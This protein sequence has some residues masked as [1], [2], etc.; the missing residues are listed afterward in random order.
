MSSK[1]YHDF[2]KPLIYICSPNQFEFIRANELGYEN[3]LY[4]FL[5]YRN[6]S[7]TDLN[8][9]GHGSKDV[10]E[11][12]NEM[13]VYNYTGLQVLD[14]QTV[15]KQVFMEN[16]GHCLML[17]NFSKTSLRVITF[18]NIIFISNIL[19]RILISFLLA[20]FIG[21]ILVFFH[22]WFQGEK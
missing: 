8:W 2:D 4:Y 1:L 3:K 21:G 11:T 10:N 20:G 19:L 7:E 17:F 16:F 5:G 9:L 18:N 22:R 13:F 14:D 15:T 6:D 12:F